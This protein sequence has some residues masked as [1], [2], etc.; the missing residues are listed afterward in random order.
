MGGTM[1]YT[2]AIEAADVVLAGVD[3]LAR[4]DDLLGILEVCLRTM[5][6]GPAS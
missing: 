6:D 4:D 2:D 3:V 1:E 5:P